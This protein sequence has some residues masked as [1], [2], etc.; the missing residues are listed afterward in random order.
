MLRIEL[1]LPL[2]ISSL[3]LSQESYNSALIGNWFEPNENY[4][5]DNIS[6]FND[7]WGHES[8]DGT[9][10]ALMGGWD[11]TYIVD[12]TTNPSSPQLVSFIP[13]STSSHRDIKTYQNFILKRNQ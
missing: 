6:D 4:W 12:I 8:E 9:M 7:V 13:G 1:I 10:Y 5:S 11:G 2:F 3:L